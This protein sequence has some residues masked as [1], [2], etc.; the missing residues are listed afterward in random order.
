[1]LRKLKNQKLGGQSGFTLIEM[2]TVVVVL[3]ILAMIIIPQVTVPIKDQSKASF[4]P[5]MVFEFPASKELSGDCIP[6]DSTDKPT[7]FIMN[8]WQLFWSEAKN[9]K[10]FLEMEKSLKEQYPEA[11]FIIQ[12]FGVFTVQTVNS[13]SGGRP[14][15]IKWS[16]YEDGYSLWYSPTHTMDADC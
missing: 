10:S 9:D 2:L 5:G 6:L 4:P 1:M 15:P 7:E 8:G 13:A 14:K 3:G 16:F 11:S 12:P